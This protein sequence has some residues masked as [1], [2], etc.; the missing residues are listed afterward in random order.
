MA[1]TD[2][3]RKAR[4][5]WKSRAIAEWG[6]FVILRHADRQ[7]HPEDAGS[8]PGRAG[9]RFAIEPS[10][11]YERAFSVVAA[12]SERRDHPAAAREDR[13]P[14]KPTSRPPDERA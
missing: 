1:N 4:L 13:D 3:R 9:P 12:R 14:A 7:V 11:N 5:Q 2:T 10:G 8:A 6:A